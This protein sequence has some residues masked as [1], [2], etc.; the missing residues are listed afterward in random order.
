LPNDIYAYVFATDAGVFAAASHGAEDSPQVSNDI[1][2]HTHKV[3]LDSN[4][5]ITGIES[6][7]DKAGTVTM[8]GNMVKIDGTGATSIDTAMAVKLTIGD[9]ICVSE[10]FSTK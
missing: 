4:N 7:A 10:V 3:T 1:D 5:C 9:Q 6:T 2:W 8:D